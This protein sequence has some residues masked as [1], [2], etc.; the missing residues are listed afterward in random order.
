MRRRRRRRP[1]RIPSDPAPESI[2]YRLATAA[3]LDGL[4]EMK[5]YKKNIISRRKKKLYKKTD[6][7]EGVTFCRRRR[8]HFACIHTRT[9]YYI[10]I[11]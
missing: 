7:V 4:E 1:N 9:F 5:N 8:R 6:A 3:E 10:R 11:I 2:N